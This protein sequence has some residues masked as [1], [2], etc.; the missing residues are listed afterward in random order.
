[1]Q[2]LLMA[3]NVQEFETRSV[4]AAVPGL[5]TGGDSNCSTSS[6]ILATSCLNDLAYAVQDVQGEVTNLSNV[7]SA[8]NTF[9][10]QLTGNNLSNMPATVSSL[11]ANN[12]VALSTDC[13]FKYT[14]SIQLVN[15]LPVVDEYACESVPTFESTFLPNA[16]K[17]YH[18]VGHTTYTLAPLSS[19]LNAANGEGGLTD[20]VL[21]QSLYLFPNISGNPI[22]G[23]FANLNIGTGY[24]SAVP[25]TSTAKPMPTSSL[26]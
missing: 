12:C 20:T 2:T 17:T 4:I 18:A 22:T 16:P 15:G 9:S 1:V 6:G 8:L 24:Y 23:N 5:L 13:G 3:L 26:C 7:S 19:N 21:T 11:F 25:V 14:T 10:G